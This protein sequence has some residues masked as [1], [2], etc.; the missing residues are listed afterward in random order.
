MIRTYAKI[1]YY[2]FKKRFKVRKG[3]QR[4]NIFKEVNVNSAIFSNSSKKL[5]ITDDRIAQTDRS[6]ERS[7]R[8]ITMI[9]RKYMKPLITDEERGLDILAQGQ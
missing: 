6:I 3:K 4:Y 2:A 8:H 1:R 9:N 5:K 7:L